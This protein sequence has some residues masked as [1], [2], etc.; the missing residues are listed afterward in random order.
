MLA[1]K[2]G[3]P[4]TQCLIC[5][6][7]LDLVDKEKTVKYFLTRLKLAVMKGLNIQILCYVPYMGQ[8][9]WHCAYISLDGEKR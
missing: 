6:R 1:S 4:T 9:P 8:R 3:E 7:K 5:I 2:Q